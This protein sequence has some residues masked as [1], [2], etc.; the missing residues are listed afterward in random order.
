MARMELFDNLKQYR[1]PLSAAQRD[2]AVRFL[3]KNAR[4][5]QKYF[6]SLKESCAFLHCSVDELQTLLHFYKIDAILFRDAYRVPWY[7]LAGFLLT[8]EQDTLREDVYA[9]IRTMPR[10]PRPLTVPRTGR[11]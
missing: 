7:S 5:A 10:K 2:A 3:I 6:Y 11:H 9:Y 4:I 8:E 1:C